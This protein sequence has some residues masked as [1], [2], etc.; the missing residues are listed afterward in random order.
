MQAYKVKG[1]IDESGHL[2]INEPIKLPPGDVEIIV[3]Q[4]VS[5]TE[6]IVTPN[7]SDC[8]VTTPRILTPA[9]LIQE[10]TDIN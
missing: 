10:L 5:I 7:T 1:R 3:L 4:E 2:I 8:P 6:A 9:Q